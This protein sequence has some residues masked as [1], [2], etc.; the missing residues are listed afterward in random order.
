MNC[1]AGH[2]VPGTSDV[3]PIAVVVPSRGSNCCALSDAGCTADGAAGAATRSDP[4]ATSGRTPSA[5]AAIASTVRSLLTIH[6]SQ[7]NTGHSRPARRVRLHDVCHGSAVA[8]REAKSM[9][10]QVLT[11]GFVQ[12]SPVT[13]TVTARLQ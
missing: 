1:N 5:T 12:R 3:T 6:L 4:H 10:G 13:Q 7:K 8:V 2:E 9:R 11:I